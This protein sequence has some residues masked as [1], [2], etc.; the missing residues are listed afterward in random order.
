MTIFVNGKQKRV[1]RPPAIDGMPVDEFIR[2]N[3]DL[4]CLH[5]DKMWEEM[6]NEIP[7]TDDKYLKWHGIPTVKKIAYSCI[8]HHFLIFSMGYCL[9]FNENR[10]VCDAGNMHEAS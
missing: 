4:I 2:R 10:P 8:G 6:P 5:Q 3:A 7:V 9:K 1:K